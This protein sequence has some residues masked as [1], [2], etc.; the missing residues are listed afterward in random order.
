MVKR[1]FSNYPVIAKMAISLV[2]IIFIG[3][4]VLAPPVNAQSSK[5]IACQ[6]VDIASGDNNVTG[7]GCSSGGESLSSILADVL[8]VLSVVAG[9][10]AV[11]MIIIGGLRYVISGGN[12][13]AVASAKNT[14]IYAL[15]GVAVLILAQT[16]V[17]FILGKAWL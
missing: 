1:I 3:G 15:V 8:D 13:N 6:G 16:I 5:T 2:G 11:I 12:D 17:H 7:P 9:F 14:I 10:I 4:L